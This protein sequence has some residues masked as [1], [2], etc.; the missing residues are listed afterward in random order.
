M[1][2]FDSHCHLDVEDFD[3]DRESVLADARAAG[4]KHLM[5]PAIT[6]NHWDA[7]W[8]LC[9]G[10]PHLYPAIGL[11]PV[12]LDRHASGDTAALEQYISSHRPV[13]IGEIGLDYFVREL[14]RKRQQVILEEQ[15]AVAESQRLPVALHVRKAH[16]PMLQTLRRYNLVG[17]ICH[18][19][20]G[21][22]QQADRYLAMGFKLGFGGM[23]T[24]PNARHLHT[25]ARELPLDALVLETDAPD[26]TGVAH[27]YQRNSP[28]YLPEVLHKL[29]ELRK[30]DNAMIAAATTRNACEV[31]RLGER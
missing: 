23:L 22:L 2:L 21:S 1:E 31:L 17:G 16:E 30:A 24:Y 29:G 13:A 3:P 9:A 20:N 5:V 10:D 6:R 7:L 19:F 11:H 12:M 14:D 18:A 4:V 27:R 26:M 15:L 25:L 8:T 28:A